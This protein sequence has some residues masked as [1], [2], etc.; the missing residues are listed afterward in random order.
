[1]VCLIGIGLSFPVYVE[2]EQELFLS[3]AD[4]DSCR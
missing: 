2:V 1:M 4:D 3:F